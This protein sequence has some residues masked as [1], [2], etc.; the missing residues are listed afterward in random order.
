MSS[1]LRNN[2][3]KP[4]V[5]L[6]AGGHAKVLLSLIKAA[7]LT[8]LGVCAPELVEQGVTSWRGINVLGTGDDMHDFPP[9][10]VD[11][12]NAVG[13][14]EIRQ[15]LF[16]I[17]KD[18]G[19]YFPI[20]VHPH[21]WV[22]ESVRLGEGTQVMAGVVIQADTCI[23]MNVIINTQASIDH[24]CVLGEHVHIGPGAMLCGG[25]RVHKRAFVASGS[26]LIVGVNVGEGAVV[27]AGASVVRDIKAQQVVLPASVR[28]KEVGEATY[29]GDQ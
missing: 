26:T 3:N 22:D 20:L 7:G 21:A 28:R 1:E 2:Q 15:T 9:G 13:K 12:V 11:L 4:L 19:Y 17:F 23:G 8:V 10:R 14:L 27:G 25:V 18:K 24:D 16:T 6:G 5:L 29:C